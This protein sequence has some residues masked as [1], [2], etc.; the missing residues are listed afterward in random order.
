MRSNMSTRHV[1]DTNDQGSG[2]GRGC[3]TWLSLPM[4]T[5]MTE[6]KSNLRFI[7][8]SSQYQKRG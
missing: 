6:A 5:G 2:M 1:L 7:S 3:D 4:R 8:K